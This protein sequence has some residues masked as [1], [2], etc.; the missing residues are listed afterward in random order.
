MRMRRS[1]RCQWARGRGRSLTFSWKR[2][3]FPCPRPAPSSSSATPTS[4]LTLLFCLSFVFFSSFSACSRS[5][6]SVCFPSVFPNRFRVLCHKIVNHNIF[7][8]LILFFILLSSISLAAEDPVKNDS[9]RNQVADWVINLTSRYFASLLL[10]HLIPYSV[11]MNFP[12]HNCLFLM[13]VKYSDEYVLNMLKFVS[14]LMYF[15]LKFF[16]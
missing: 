10:F 6:A 14:I 3:P 5:S 12:L 13:L 9:F 11:P 1:Q 15:S 7:T 4:N 8:N 16:L 2:R